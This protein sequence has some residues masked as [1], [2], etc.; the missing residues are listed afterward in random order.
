MASYETELKEAIAS[1][2]KVFEPYALRPHVHGCTHC[3]S[4]SDNACLHERPL[5]ELTAD[6]LEKFAYKAL[7][8][9]GDINDFR[10]FLPRLMECLANQE[11]TIGAI[12]AEIV[13]GKLTYGE[14]LS[15]PESEKLAI[16]RYFSAVLKGS[17][18]AFHEDA[19]APWV[20]ICAIGRAEDDLSAY[21]REWESIGTFGTN[22]LA[23]LFIREGNN[24]LAKNK[25]PNAFWSDRR[26][27]M[28]QVIAWLASPAVHRLLEEAFFRAAGTSQA[29]EISLACTIQEALADRR[30]VNQN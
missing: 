7:S 16:R 29:E 3:V 25:L 17:I 14:W 12:D 20:W 5:R 19:D 23:Y 27:Q 22:P 26:E 13:L 11:H 9:W 24:L 28:M 30:S 2:Y 18:F 1:L 10:H 6:Q 15:W 21:F 8:T 4:D